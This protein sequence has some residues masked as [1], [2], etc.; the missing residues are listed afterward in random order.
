M[1]TAEVNGVRLYYESTGQGPAVLFLHGYTGSG[2][3]WRYQAPAVSRT[4][5]AITLDYRGHRN[6]Q[7]PQTEE[8]YSIEIFS[9]D[10]RS[11]LECLDVTACCL[12]GHSMGGFTALQFALDHPEMVKGLVLVDT[13]SG[14]FETVPG[15]AELRAKLDELARTEGMEAAF[16]Y[17]ASHNPVRVERFRKHPEFHEVTR[18]KMMQT[19]VDGYIYTARSFRKWKPVT[20]R[21][22]EITAPTL[23]FWGDEDSAFLKPSRTLESG[24]RGSQLITVNGA[25]HNPHEEAPGIFNKALLPF[26]EGLAW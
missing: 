17:E 7:A 10:V 2:D 5:R 8:D 4:H 24:I 20:G 21:L 23:I 3:D 6:S 18:R 26:L 19:S 13:S 16:E 1:P 25:G 15:F 9:E 11:L 12:V 14:E 22:G